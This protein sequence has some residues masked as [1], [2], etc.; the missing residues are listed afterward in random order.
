MPSK[1]GANITITVTVPW[2]NPTTNTINFLQQ[3]NQKLT[4][5]YNVTTQGT[6][7]LTSL[8]I[9]LFL[10]VNET[11]KIQ[12]SFGCYL[13][14]ISSS[15]CPLLVGW[16]NGWVTDAMGGC[17]ID[18]EMELLSICTL[19]T[20]LTSISSSKTEWMELTKY[21]LPNGALCCLQGNT[22]RGS[23]ITMTTYCDIGN[24]NRYWTIYGILQWVGPT[25][26]KWPPGHLTSLTLSKL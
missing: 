12:S 7:H 1:E 14:P 4:P 6:Q 10:R 18:R 22:C 13:Y 21:L 3:A 25:S 9:H 17:P 20:Y 11:D 24:Q 5:A 19:R 15:Y 2:S 23:I 8:K 26:G 16:Y